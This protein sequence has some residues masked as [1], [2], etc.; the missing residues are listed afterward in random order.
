MLGLRHELPA[1][2]SF[3]PPV[4][5]ASSPQAP[6]SSKHQVLTKLKA[7]GLTL[8]SFSRDRAIARNPQTLGQHGGC[9]LLARNTLSPAR[10]P[11]P[12]D[13]PAEPLRQA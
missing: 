5:P 1:K 3:W 13:T 4:A 10:E 8:V 7:T 6:E 9:R 12:G 2:G 11:L